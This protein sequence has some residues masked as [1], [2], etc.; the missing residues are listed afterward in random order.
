MA[1]YLDAADR[2]VE[3]LALAENIPLDNL[4]AASTQGLLSVSTC[5]LSDDCIMKGAK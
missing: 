2:K 3:S 4:L 1:L 5:G